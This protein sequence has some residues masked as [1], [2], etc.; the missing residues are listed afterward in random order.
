MQTSETSEVAWRGA[1]APAVLRGSDFAHRNGL[2]FGLSLF[3]KRKAIILHADTA[4]DSFDGVDAVPVAVFTVT[5]GRVMP[6]QL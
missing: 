1:R 3:D 4:L 2:S 5:I 6:L